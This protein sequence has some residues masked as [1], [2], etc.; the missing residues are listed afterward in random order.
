MTESATPEPQ[1]VLRVVK[2]DPTPEELAALVAVVTA[3]AT[4]VPAAPEPDRAGDWATYWRT[5]KRPLHP[6]P[7]RW[8][9]S[10]H[11]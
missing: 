5:A 2:G 7:G 8:R 1:P 4:A 11:P 10:A 6:G 3:R 9:A